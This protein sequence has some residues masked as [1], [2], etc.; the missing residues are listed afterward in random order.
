MPSSPQTPVFT[1]C[2]EDLQEVA[3]MKLG[4]ALTED[5]LYRVIMCVH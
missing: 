2:V 3:Q 1:L 5:E 4:R